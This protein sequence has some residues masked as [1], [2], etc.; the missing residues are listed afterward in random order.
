MM[1]IVLFFVNNKRVGPPV[2]VWRI[3]IKVGLS[4]LAVGLVQEKKS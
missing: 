2:S 1:H 3:F 4:R